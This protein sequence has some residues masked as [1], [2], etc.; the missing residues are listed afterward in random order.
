ML[1]DDDAAVRPAVGGARRVEVPTDARAHPLD[2][3]P[4]DRE[5]K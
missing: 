2:A 4:D 3:H 5:E 1:G